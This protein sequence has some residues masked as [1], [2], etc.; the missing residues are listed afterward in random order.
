MHLAQWNGLFCDSFQNTYKK[1]VLPTEPK[2][3]LYNKYL[4]EFGI[5][6]EYD[7]LNNFP[8]RF[9]IACSIYKTIT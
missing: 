5:I 4:S 8:S 6:I 3:T 7:S 1:N 2:T 9:R